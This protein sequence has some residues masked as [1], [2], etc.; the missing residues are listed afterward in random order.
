MFIKFGDLGLAEGTARSPGRGGAEQGRPPRPPRPPGPPGPRAAARPAEAARFDAG[1]A[2]N[3]RPGGAS[4]GQRRGRGASDARRTSILLVLRAG[5]SVDGRGSTPAFRTSCKNG[6]FCTRL[7][8]GRDR[9]ITAD[10]V[11]CLAGPFQI[12]KRPFE[13]HGVDGEKCLNFDRYTLRSGRRLGLWRTGSSE[14]KL[15]WCD[16]F[17]PC[18]KTRIRDGVTNEMHS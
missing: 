14:P 17:R 6:G 15:P 13:D 4:R 11:G 18:M 8:R 3:A 1:S 7:G 12:R 2:G 10:R 5:R 9:P 16:E